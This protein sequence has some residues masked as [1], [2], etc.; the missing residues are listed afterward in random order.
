MSVHI[1]ESNLQPERVIHVDNLRVE[2][3]ADRAA[4]GRAAGTWA[5][6]ILRQALTRKGAARAIFAAAPSQNEL[7]ANLVQA[8]SIDWA[9]L[10]AFHLDE[11][12]GLAGGAPQSFQTYL[13]E[14]L[15]S[16]V[17]P[18]LVNYLDGATTDPE[19]AAGEYGRLLQADELDLACIGIGENGHIAFNDPPLADFNDPQ[20]VRIVALDET[21]RVQ[22][23]HDGC[24]P[25][26]AQVPR[27]AMTV[28]IPAIM[29]ARSI[30]CVVP[31][32]TKAKAVFDTLNGPIT[33]LC[34]GSILRQHPAARLFVDRESA[35]LLK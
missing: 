23:V 7:L 4:L 1:P 3:F 28:T 35:A 2:V 27:Q 14:H 21:S 5:A 12:L 34:P 33:P 29:A 13:K 22:Q 15:F 9:R 32:P 11:Y 24:F 8:G 6:S 31:G 18:G 10:T 25:E 17:K 30:V 19:A 16:L 20:K 26:L